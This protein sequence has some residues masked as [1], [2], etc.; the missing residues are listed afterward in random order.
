MFMENKENN[1][2]QNCSNQWQCDGINCQGYISTY[3][4][5]IDIFDEIGKYFNPKK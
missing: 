2:C 5:I 1:N 3:E 4:G